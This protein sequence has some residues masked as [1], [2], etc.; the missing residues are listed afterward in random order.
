M[1]RRMNAIGIAML[2]I[3]MLVSARSAMPT[4]AAAEI[5]ITGTGDLSE[6][7]CRISGF[8]DNEEVS[9]WFT[10]PHEQVMAGNYHT[11]NDRGRHTITLRLPRHLEPGRWA[12]TVHGL[13]SDRE[14]IGYFE[15]AD[16][17]RNATVVVTPA[18]ARPGELIRLDGRG[19]ASDE[20]A[21]YWMTDPAGVGRPGG[22]V[23]IDAAGNVVIMAPLPVD[24]PTGQWAVTVYG[25]SSD[26]LGVGLFQVTAG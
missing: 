21:S 2:V 17:G 19:Y 14:V 5:E 4:E 9:T 13:E 3:A 11:V 23:Q 7:V 20:M 8:R 24:A 26:R 18:T 22:Y 1:R 25:L 6:F 10:G 16:R 12:I 15:L